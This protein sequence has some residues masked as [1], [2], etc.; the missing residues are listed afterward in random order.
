MW[1]NKDAPQSRVGFFWCGPLDDYPSIKLHLRQNWVSRT[2]YFNC[3]NASE[4]LYVD[5]FNVHFV[6]TNSFLLWMK[7]PFFAFTSV[8]AQLFLP[9]FGVE[10]N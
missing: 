3:I 9:S 7:L 1:H 10:V 2:L 6:R 4:L 8:Q 5:V